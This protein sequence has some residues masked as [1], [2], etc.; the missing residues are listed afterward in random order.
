[1]DKLDVLNYLD[2]ISEEVV[3]VSLEI[4]NNPETS[5]NEVKAFN[6]FKEVYKIL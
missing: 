2:E 3:E 6:L 5:E 1:M 4:W